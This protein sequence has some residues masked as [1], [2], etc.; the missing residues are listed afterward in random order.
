MT[1]P[2]PDKR[3]AWIRGVC[4]AVNQQIGDCKNRG[5]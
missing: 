1:G 2:G 4:G 3:P 5:A